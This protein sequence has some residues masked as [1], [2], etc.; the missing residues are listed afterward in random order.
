[1]EDNAESPKD[2]ANARDVFNAYLAFIAFGTTSAGTSRYPRLIDL[3]KTPKD[4]VPGVDAVIAYM[5]FHFAGVGAQ[6]LRTQ[7]EG[8]YRLIVAFTYLGS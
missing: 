8:K 1:M 5:Q 6:G 7:V 4:Q 2:E 3:E